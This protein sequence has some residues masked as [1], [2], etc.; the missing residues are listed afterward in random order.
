ML[1]LFFSVVCVS[2]SET[3]FCVFKTDKI[4]TYLVTRIVLG[5]SRLGKGVTIWKGEEK[6]GFCGAGMELEV[7]P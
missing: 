2:N 4:R 1:E 7:P 6:D 3:T 5:F